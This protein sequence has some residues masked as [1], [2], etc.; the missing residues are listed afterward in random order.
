MSHLNM[1]LKTEQRLLETRTGG[2][3]TLVFSRLIENA[4]KSSPV[5]WD[6]VFLLQE[7]FKQNKPKKW[8]K[9][10]ILL[11]KKM[12]IVDGGICEMYWTVLC[13]I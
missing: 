1:T 6:W 8:T 5:L 9:D 2:K 11:N 12:Y 3:V 13:F 7:N 4:H 10:K